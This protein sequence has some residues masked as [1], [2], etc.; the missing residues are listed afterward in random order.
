[1]NYCPIKMLSSKDSYYQTCDGGRCQLYDN[2]RSQ[3]SI[4]TFLTKENHTNINIE[5]KQEPPVMPPQ[6][7]MPYEANRSDEQINYE[8][9]KKERRKYTYTIN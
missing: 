5:N 3:C 6:I 1:M 2:K 8:D 9:L 4:K 7:H